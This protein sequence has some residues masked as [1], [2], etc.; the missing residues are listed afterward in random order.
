MP[1]NIK[2]IIKAGCDNLHFLV[3]NIIV[4][5]IMIIIIIKV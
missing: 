5:V 3:L 2:L 1:C 4:I